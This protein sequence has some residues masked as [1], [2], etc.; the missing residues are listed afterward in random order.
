MRRRLLAL[1]L[2]SAVLLPAGT[3]LA[4]D[5]PPF[6]PYPLGACVRSRYMEPQ[7]LCVYLDDVAGTLAPQG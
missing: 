4:D 1:T 2:L 3:A 7:Q 5:P 6:D